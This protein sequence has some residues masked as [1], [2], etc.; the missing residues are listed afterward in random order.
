MATHDHTVR[1]RPSFP[2]DDTLTELPSA[3]PSADKAGLPPQSSDR[4]DTAIAVLTLVRL[5]TDSERYRKARLWGFPAKPLDYPLS[6]E[7]TAAL[8]I[9]IRCLEQAAFGHEHVSTGT[10]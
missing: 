8:T 1:A 10:Q 9:A 2:D 6:A 5:R 3:S 4:I 7:V